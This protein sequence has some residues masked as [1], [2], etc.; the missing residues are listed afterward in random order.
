[1]PESIYSALADKYSA[2]SVMYGDNSPTIALEITSGDTRITITSVTNSSGGTDDLYGNLTFNYKLENDRIG[3]SSMKPMF[4]KSGPSGTFT[5][6]TEYTGA[7][8]EGKTALTT[9]AAGKAHV[10]DWNTVTDLGGYYKGIVYIKF[11]A[12]DRDNFIGD[13]MDATLL[14][15]LVDNAPDSGV[16][17]DPVDGFF[18]KETTPMIEGTIPSHK[19]GY[20][21]MHIK[22][23]IATD[24]AFA[25]IELTLESAISQDGW[26]YYDDSAWIDL[27]ITGIPVA[28]DNTLIGNHWR[29]Y[30]PTENELTKGPKYI[31]FAAGEISA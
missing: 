21:N 11:R 23:E 1:M 15:V 3:V 20:V 7:T 26:S 14:Q 24:S 18:T 12:Y 22:V 10:F 17:T 6:M 4:S 31:R 19:A 29:V 25:N 27:P 9:T 16:I 5:E 8:S 28:G 30:I 2:H 13:Y